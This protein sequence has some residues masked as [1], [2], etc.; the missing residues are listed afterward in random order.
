[1]TKVM[2]LDGN[3]KYYFSDMTVE[4]NEDEYVPEN[5]PHLS[6][7]KQKTLKISGIFLK[8]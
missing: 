5:V 3:D 2:G 1:M 6:L 4:S 7:T 8:S